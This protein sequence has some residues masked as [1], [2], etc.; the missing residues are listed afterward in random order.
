MKTALIEWVK[1]F[2]DICLIGIGVIIAIL[3]IGAVMF[4]GFKIVYSL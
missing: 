3:T 4:L 1:W 2:A